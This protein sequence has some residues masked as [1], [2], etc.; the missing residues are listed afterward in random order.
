MKH[1]CR[2]VGTKENEN[3]IPASFSVIPTCSESFLLVRNRKERFWTSQNDKRTSPDRSE[4]SHGTSQHDKE[5]D[6]QV[7]KVLLTGAGGFIGRHSIPFLLKND[8]EVHAVYNIAET[9]I[10]AH[11]NLFWHKCD[12]LNSAEQ[13]Y[14][15]SKIKPTHLLHFAWYTAHGKYWT[16]I[17]NLRW[18]QASLDLFVNFA[19]NG[20]RRAVGAGTC[21]EYDWNYGYCS[22]EITPLKPSTLYGACKN[23]LQEM[24]SR[25]SKQA[26][27]SFAWGRIFFLYGHYEYPQRLVPYVICSLLKNQTAQC[28]HGNQIR[29]FLYVED[30]ASAFVALVENDVQGAVNIASGKPLA[31]KEVIYKIAQKIGGVDRIQLGV[32]PSPADEPQT[33]TAD[34]RRLTEEV[35]WQPEYD[36]DRGLEHTIGWWRKHLNITT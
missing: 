35:K 20:G 11:K 26:G 1:T 36:I 14:L 21:A 33:L 17:E 28:S 6:F 10:A 13:K 15:L 19:E 9:D 31:L 23:S 8:Y 2:P 30:V 3:V 7:K 18:V 27:I 32:I 16:A 25:Y 29:D 22:E 4:A 34:V 5:V 24:L 12:L